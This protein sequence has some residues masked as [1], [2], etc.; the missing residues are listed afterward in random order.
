MGVIAGAAVGAA[1]AAISAGVQA[2]SAKSAA[3]KASK[4]S[5]KIAKESRNERTAIS[6]ATKAEQG[7]AIRQREASEETRLRV[8]MQLG[9][10]GTYGPQA[11]PP[12][13]FGFEPGGVGGMGS[14]TTVPGGLWGDTESQTGAEGKSRWNVDGNVMDPEAMTS[15]IMSQPG[16]RAVSGMVAEANQL[17]NRQGPLWDELNNSVTGSIYEGAAASQRQQMEEVARMTAQGGNARRAGLAMAQRFK[18]QE[19][20]NRQRMGQLWQSRMKLEEYRVTA[21]QK[22]LSYASDWVNNQAGIRDNFTSA[23][24]NL[25]TMWSS[26]IAPQMISAAS[27]SEAGSQRVQAGISQAQMD[28]SAAKGAAI[29]G[30]LESMTG[31]LQQGMAESGYSLFGNNDSSAGGGGFTN[32]IDSQ[33]DAPA[34]GSGVLRPEYQ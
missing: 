27:S 23:L 15:A 26:Q 20:V 32:S 1:G 22:N 14:S 33:F 5:Q 7:L 17:M 34:A 28:A 29:S 10:P 2:G 25:R 8:G 16:A 21:S 4:A 3:K 18:V 24:T 30:A 9:A 13:L 31:A 6:N 11:G 19:D 12:G